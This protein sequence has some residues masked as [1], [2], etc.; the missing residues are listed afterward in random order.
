MAQQASQF[1]PV[2]LRHALPG[3]GAELARIYVQSW[4]ETYPGL[5]P[6]RV[7]INLSEKR[8]TDA[9]RRQV[10]TAGREHAVVVAEVKAY[11]LTGLASLGPSRDRG[12]PYQGE[13]YALYLDPN[14]T[15]RGIGRSLLRGAFRV[16]FERGHKSAVIWALK[17]NPAR[18]FYEAQ[19]GR[20]VATRKGNMWGAE[21]MEVGFGWENLEA[22][23][24][25]AS[26]TNTRR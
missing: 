1:G 21:V 26:S 15:G 3:D 13:V 4:R 23:I 16:L 20:E 7:L 8:Q 18:Y 22:I 24:G 19:G 6:D 17:G 11:G 5:L 10:M 9:W 25:G 2:I 12:I 14:F